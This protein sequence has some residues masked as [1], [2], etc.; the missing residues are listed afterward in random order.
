MEPGERG[1]GLENI[2]SFHFRG[3]SEKRRLSQPSRLMGHLRRQQP[4]TTPAIYPLQLDHDACSMQENVLFLHGALHWMGYRRIMEQS[5]R[6]CLEFS[7]LH[8]KCLL[9]SCS[10]STLLQGSRLR[11]YGSMRGTIKSEGRH[12]R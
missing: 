11:M 12:W 1:Q 2:P 8:F 3:C 6:K 4:P 7:W 5:T 9:L 10:N